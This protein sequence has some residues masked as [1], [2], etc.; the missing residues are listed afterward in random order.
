M[1][2]YI[3]R[4]I[5]LD[6]PAIRLLRLRGGSFTDNIQGDIFEGWINQLEGGIPYDALSYTWGSTEKAVQIMVNG[7]TLHI[8][9]N[10]Y[11]AL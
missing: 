7:Y 4:P 1:T 10:L 11:T 9:S 5:N 3:Y 2:K 6:R 8:T